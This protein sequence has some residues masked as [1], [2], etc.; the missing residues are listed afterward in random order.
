MP[1]RVSKICSLD[2][3]GSVSPLLD[4]P[5]LSNVMKNTKEIGNLTELQCITGLYELGCDVSIPFGNSQKYDL[6]IDYQ[7]K[8][9]KV[10]VK[11]A[12][13]K[14]TDNEVTHFSIRTRW[15]GHNTNGYTQTSYTKQDIDF[16]A[17]FHQGKVFLIPIEECSGAEK[18]IRY[19]L[20]KNG[21]KTGINFAKDYF[22]EEVLKRL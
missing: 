13:E 22:A 16:F 12:N 14:K 19:S 11:H 21:Q 8:L 4:K 3:T 18:T 1:N 7:G 15:Q 2:A 5:L 6:I 10:Q 9:Y 20:P 17:T